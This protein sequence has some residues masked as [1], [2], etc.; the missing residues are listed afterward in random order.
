[1][2]NWIKAAA[3]AAMLLFGATTVSAGKQDFDLINATGY[4]I[5]ELYVAPSSSNNWEEDVLGRDTLGD[6]EGVTINFAPNQKACMYDLLIVWEDGDQATWEGFNLCT[7][8]E[9]TLYWNNGK[10]TAE[11]H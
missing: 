11:Y 10:A 1:M 2:Y 5:A 8:S 3:M 7:V 9:I 6:G 4:T